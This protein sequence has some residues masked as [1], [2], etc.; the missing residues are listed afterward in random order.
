MVAGEQQNMLKQFSFVVCR[1]ASQLADPFHSTHSQS[2]I[3]N[4]TKDL[5]RWKF[6]SRPG[7]VGAVSGLKTT[8]RMY[9]LRIKCILPRPGYWGQHCFSVLIV[10]AL[11]NRENNV[12]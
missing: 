2:P 5:K 7:L 6:S 4:L 3:N 11:R 10:T 12:M 1:Q 9:K 8:Q